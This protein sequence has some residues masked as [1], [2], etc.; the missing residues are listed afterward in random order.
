MVLPHHMQDSLFSVLSRTL[1]ENHKRSIDL[2]VY[3]LS[4]FYI[5]S[6]YK[7]FQEVLTENKVGATIIEVLENQIQRFDLMYSEYIE[8]WRRN[9]ENDRITA[10]SQLKKLNVLIWKQDK[11]FYVCLNV[12]FNI[13]ANPN[14]EKKM[15]KAGLVQILC[16]CLERNDFH[17]LIIT[18]AFLRKLSVMA[19]YKEQMVMLGLFSW[20]LELSKSLRDFLPA[21]MTFCSTL[22]F[23]FTTIFPS[24]KMQEHRSKRLR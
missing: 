23:L 8:M 22:H 17:L 12:L 2:S 13:S 15:R 4:T 9:N 1:G 21:T 18:L 7:Q 24:I 3:I 19:E 11:L 6:N 10:R 5:L 20:E 14:I 16:R